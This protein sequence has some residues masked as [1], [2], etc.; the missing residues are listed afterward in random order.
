MKSS[1]YVFNLDDMYFH[2]YVNAIGQI[3]MND[4]GSDK[5]NEDTEWDGGTDTYAVK[6][7]S[8]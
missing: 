7:T 6:I 4:K 2:L 1:D 5:Y 8:K 3:S